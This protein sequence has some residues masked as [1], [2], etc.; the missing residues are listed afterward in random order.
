MSRIQ[1]QNRGRKAAI[2]LWELSES[3]LEFFRETLPA[4]ATILDGDATRVVGNAEI[5][6]DYFPAL[7]WRDV[8]VP[9]PAQYGAITLNG[10][11]KFNEATSAAKPERAVTGTS[12]APGIHS[13]LLKDLRRHY[14]ANSEMLEREYAARTELLEQRYDEG[15]D[16]LIIRQLPTQLKDQLKRRQ[17]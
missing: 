9:L 7:R 16:M 2:E 4:G 17:D 1:L 15:R 5:E 8:V 14:G 13:T 3:D 10:R 12:Q 11:W 6:E